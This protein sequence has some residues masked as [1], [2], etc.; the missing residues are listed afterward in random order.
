M[1][2]W[3]V[4]LVL[5]LRVLIGDF[6]APVKNTDS[7]L[8]S[9]LVAAGILVNNEVDLVNDYIFD[10]AN[11]T[12][13]PDP[14]DIG[15]IVIQSLL[16]LKSACILN[17]TD[18]QIALRQ[19]ISVRDGDSMINT[20]VSFGGYK[21]ILQLGPCAAYERLKWQIQSSNIGNIGGAVMS[22]FRGPNDSPI[23]TVLWWYDEFASYLN[24]SRITQR[25]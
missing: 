24:T 19:G 13:T 12:I 7:Y 2:T 21:D 23:D 14:I 1:S 17:Q 18:F 25:F 9:V 22:P 10:I 3:D 6:N 4:D 5:T 11:I 16:P 15:D 8:K 20:S